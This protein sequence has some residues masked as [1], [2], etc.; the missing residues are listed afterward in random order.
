LLFRQI[1]QPNGI[2]ARIDRS[3]PVEALVHRDR[4]KNGARSLA[5][6]LTFASHTFGKFNASLPP[7]NIANQGVVNQQDQNIELSSFKFNRG[8]QPIVVQLSSE[9]DG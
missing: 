2:E 7:M 3:H 5:N 8:L 6:I 1:E 4:K 9:I